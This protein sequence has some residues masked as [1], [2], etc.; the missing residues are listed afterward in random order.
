MHEKGD[1]TRALKIMYT[2][3]H[4]SIAL[5]RNEETKGMLKILPPRHREK[6][7]A[8]E[9]ALRLMPAE[10]WSTISGEVVDLRRRIASEVKGYSKS[11]ENRL[12]FRLL[13]KSGLRKAT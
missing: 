5:Q 12:A 7:A 8:K 6:T 9:L 2:K 13:E 1:E 10:R 11:A 3:R 4:W